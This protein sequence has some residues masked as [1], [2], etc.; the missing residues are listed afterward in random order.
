MT[1]RSQAGVTLIEMMVVVALIGLMAAISFPSVSSGLDSIRLVAAADSIA[2]FLNSGLNRAERRQHP[3]EITISLGDHSLTMRSADPGFVRTLGMPEGVTIAA[4]HPP[5]PPGIDE[6]SR[7]FL[8]Y[9]AGAIPRI[10]IEIANRRGARRIVRIDPT[11]G[12]PAIEQ[13]Q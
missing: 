9:P 11:T 7:T 6:P 8:V 4:V 12:V 2:A 1:S 10:G 13:V 3:V 5:L